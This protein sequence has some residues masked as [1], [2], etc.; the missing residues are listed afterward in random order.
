MDKEE[1]CHIKMENLANN[2]CR[3]HIYFLDENTEHFCG[4]YRRA[5]AR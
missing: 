3:V 5:K 1:E 2:I 4:K